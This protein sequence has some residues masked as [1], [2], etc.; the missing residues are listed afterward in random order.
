[1]KKAS[2][3]APLLLLC[4]APAGAMNVQIFLAKAERL[5]KRGPLAIFSSDLKLL[6]NQVQA[7]MNAIKAEKDQADAAHRPSAFCPPK[8]Q[9]IN[10][11]DKDILGAMRAVPPAK[12]AATDTRDALRAYFGRRFP[13]KA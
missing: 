13:C 6:M 10:M 7:D 8:G 3:I 4:A 12:R 11:T 5:E 1:M 2:A 9:K